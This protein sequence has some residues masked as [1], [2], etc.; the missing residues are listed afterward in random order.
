MNR[1]RNVLAAAGAMLILQAPAAAAPGSVIDG[2]QLDSSWDPAGRILE[3]DRNWNII[4][5]AQSRDLTRAKTLAQAGAAGAMSTLLV[6]RAKYPERTLTERYGWVMRQGTVDPREIVPLQLN[7]ELKQQRLPNGDWV[8]AIWAWA[9]KRKYSLQY[10]R[11]HAA[12]PGA[13]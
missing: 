9:D 8:V 5:Y 13:R 4:M 1:I 10:V 12:L 2:I 6:A 3:G 11:T 7:T